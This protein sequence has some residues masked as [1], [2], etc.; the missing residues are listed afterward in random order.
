TAR[1]VA[2][3]LVAAFL[4]AGFLA[5]FL[6]D[7]VFFATAFFAEAFFGVTLR[8]A[9]FFAADLR[10]IAMRSFSC[11]EQMKTGPSMRALSICGITHCTNRSFTGARAGQHSRKLAA[12][13]QKPGCN[14]ASTKCGS[15]RWLTRIV[16][17]TP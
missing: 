13:D 12:A 16:N 7:V 14:R 9:A 10:V 4:A 3:F 15:T 17:N 5:A 11:G 2:I 8:D 1:F 6:L